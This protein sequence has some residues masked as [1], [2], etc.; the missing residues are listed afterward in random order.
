[1]GLAA[2]FVLYCTVLYCT[3]L[4]CK[5]CTVL[6]YILYC[7]LLH[8]PALYCTAL[9]CTVLSI[10][11]PWLR[12][13][14]LADSAGG[15]LSTLVGSDRCWRGSCIESLDAVPLVEKRSA[16]RGL[17]NGGWRTRPEAS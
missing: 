11:L 7:T 14:G 16:S 6:H 3:V 13:W 17:G 12:E 15:L 2:A 8:R 10:R 5:Y 9:Y 4:H 1:M